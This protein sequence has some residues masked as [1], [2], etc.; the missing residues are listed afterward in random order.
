MDTLV[1]EELGI[2]ETSDHVPSLDGEQK[3]SDNIPPADDSDN[4]STGEI[5]KPNDNIEIPPIISSDDVMIGNEIGKS[6]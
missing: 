1:A 6:W 3:P 5:E 2:V 4:I